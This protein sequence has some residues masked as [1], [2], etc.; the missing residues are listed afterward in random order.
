MPVRLSV[1]IVCLVLAEVVSLKLLY[2]PFIVPRFQETAHPSQ[3]LFLLS[4]LPIFLVCLAFG[5]RAASWL[6][7]VLFVLL[8]ALATTGFQLLAAAM[9]QPAHG[10]FA[11][12][13]LEFW[14]SYLAIVTGGLLVLAASAHALRRI[15][16]RIRHGS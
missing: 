1:A 5:F 3:W 7:V 2:E 15:A 12:G 11:E 16:V 13:P 8:G 4:M 6:E 10:K 14:V 9:H